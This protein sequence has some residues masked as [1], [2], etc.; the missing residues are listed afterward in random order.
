MASRKISLDVIGVATP[1]HENWDAMHGDER[2]KFCDQCDKHVHNLSAMTRADAEAFIN[3]NP[4]GVCIRMHKGADGRVITA[5]EPCQPTAMPHRRMAA[6]TL[7]PYLAILAGGA[8]GLASCSD[9]SAPDDA[10]TAPASTDTQTAQQQEP[11]THPA[12]EP[13]PYI[14]MGG[15]CPPPWT[16]EQ[17]PQ[18]TPPEEIGEMEVLLGDIAIDVPH[19]PIP[20]PEPIQGLI[21]Q[22]PPDAEIQQLIEQ[23]QDGEPQQDPVPIPE[24]IQPQ[25]D[26]AL[27]ELVEQAA[28]PRHEILLGRLVSPPDTGS[29]EDFIEREQAQQP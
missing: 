17:E 11:E 29:L 4:T 7:L 15:A 25:L 18:P 6:Q 16:P 13:E 23:Q 14:L 21:I 26:Q 5:D 28:P 20:H 1:C 8:A 12:A 10:A 9:A 27:Q 2:Q 19:E 22:T 24:D 3:A